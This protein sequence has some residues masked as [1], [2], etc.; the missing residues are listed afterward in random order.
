MNFGFVV[1]ISVGAGLAVGALVSLPFWIGQAQINNG[2]RKA[3]RPNRHV[4]TVRFTG[5]FNYLAQKLNDFLISNEF[6]SQ[7]YGG[8]EMVYRC[9]SGYW[10]PARF[11]KFS[12]IPDGVLIEAFL[13]IYGYW[14]NPISG[15][16]GWPV[17]GPFLNTINR[18]ENIIQW[19]EYNLQTQRQQERQYQWQQPQTQSAPADS[20]T[21][22]Q[23]IPPED[24]P[25][26]TNTD[27][28][29]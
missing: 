3:K 11:V 1:L 15:I 25:A 4:R 14:E 20:I 7:P 19:E 26:E 21:E 16:M 5:D 9:G 29:K 18:L 6:Q 28:D 17:H 23:N 8:D 12:Y 2:T 24:I 10:L 13:I 22:A 27:K